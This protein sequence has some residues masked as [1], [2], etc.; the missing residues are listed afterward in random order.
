MDARTSPFAQCR[1]AW[2][3]KG[4]D[5]PAS[6]WPRLVPR[7][8]LEAFCLDRRGMGVPAESLPMALQA[9]SVCGWKPA[10]RSGR[11]GL[12]A[13]ARDPV[14]GEGCRR[15]LELNR[16]AAARTFMAWEALQDMLLQ[17]MQQKRKV[18]K[19]QQTQQ[20]QQTQ[21]VLKLQDADLRQGPRDPDRPAQNG[22]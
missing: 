1:L 5:G 14:N 22:L 20:M 8:G 3:V 19:V 10:F 11:L 4:A 7:P 2:A 17:Q 13:G 6:R 9:Y 16:E 15:H 12:E 18:L 21:Q